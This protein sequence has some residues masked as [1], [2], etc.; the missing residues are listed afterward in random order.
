MWNNLRAWRLGRR[1]YFS[2]DLPKEAYPAEYQLF[3]AKSQKSTFL[4]A[5]LKLFPCFDPESRLIR[6]MERVGP[7]SRDEL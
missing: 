1:K 4:N 6:I 5:A 2:L 3:A 7:A